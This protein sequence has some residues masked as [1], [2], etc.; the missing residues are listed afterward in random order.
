[1]LTPRRSSG[2]ILRPIWLCCGFSTPPGFPMPRWETPPP[3]GWDR[4][5][6]PSA[7]LH[8]APL[9]P[10]NSGGPLVDSRGRVVGVNTAMILGAQGINFAVPAD[11]ASWVIPQLFLHGRVRRGYLGIGARQRPL[12]RKWVQLHRL[13]SSF[14]VE[15]MVIE[16]GGPADRPTG[17]LDLPAGRRTAGAVGGSHRSSLR[18]ASH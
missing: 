5:S 6:L 17:R 2:T 8:T 16:K 3:C 14:A 4:G 1:M 11:T 18:H 12:D 13:P 10:G 15:V 9:N 7:I